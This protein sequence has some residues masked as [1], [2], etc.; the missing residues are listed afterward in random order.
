MCWEPIPPIE[1]GFEL[2]GESSF[3]YAR[4]CDGSFQLLKSNFQSSFHIDSQFLLDNSFDFRISGGSIK[5]KEFTAFEA[6][7]WNSNSPS[8]AAIFESGSRA[9]HGLKKEI[10]R[11]LAALGE[12]EQNYPRV[13]KVLSDQQDRFFKSKQSDKVNLKAEA[14]EGMDSPKLI[15]HVIDNSSII[16][17]I[18]SEFK[19]QNIIELNELLHDLLY[20]NIINLKL[21]CQ[22]II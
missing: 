19:N 13:A 20:Y 18:L 3:L 8:L 14:E 16:L 12:A 4:S 5:V 15:S 6:I 1:G 21:N 11:S 17:N 10:C 2:T 7:E 22:F 9:L